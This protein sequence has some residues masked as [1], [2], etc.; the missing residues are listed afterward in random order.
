MAAGGHRDV[1]GSGSRCLLECRER[2]PGGRGSCAGRRARIEK[3]RKAD[4]TIRVVDGQ[5]APV[6]GAEVKVQQTR[7]AFLFGSNIFLWGRAGNDRDEAAYRERFAALLNYATLPFYWPSYERRQG[8]P[9]HERIERIARWCQQQK[10]ATK[11]HPLAWNYADPPWL[12]E[13]PEQVRR[14]QLDRIEDCV[15]RFAGLIDR[16][17]VVNEAAHFERESFL[18]RAPKMTRMWQQAGHMELVHQCFRQARQA[19]AHATLLINDYRVDEA[20]D[21]V[22]Q[23]LTGQDGKPLYD[24][25]GI[26]SH[27]HRQT[28]TNEHLWQVCQRFAAYGVPLHFTETTILSGKPGWAAEQRGGLAHDGRGG[29]M[30]GGRDCPVLH[31]AFFAPRGPGHHVVG[32]F[33]SSRLAGRAGWIPASGHVAQTGL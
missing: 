1:P 21:H 5:G 29:A 13:D 14:L 7:H 11:G 18:E 27:M 32:F 22:L 10:I 6:A 4:A 9:D 17:D 28:W 26:Q 8:Q 33:G 30:A 16:W 23:Q 25:I 3:H 24:A 31:P 2:C 20:Y 19:G 15:T 12:P